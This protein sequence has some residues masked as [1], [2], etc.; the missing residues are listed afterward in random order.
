MTDTREP[1]GRDALDYVNKSVAA[2]LPEAAE[3]VSGFD[4]SSDPSTAK[5]S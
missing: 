4:L 3:T 5:R 1:C 2:R